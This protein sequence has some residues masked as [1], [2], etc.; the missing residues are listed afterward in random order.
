MVF[1]FQVCFEPEEDGAITLMSLPYRAATPTG[2]RLRKPNETS[3]K[4]SRSTLMG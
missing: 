1:R 4:P 3:K 2:E